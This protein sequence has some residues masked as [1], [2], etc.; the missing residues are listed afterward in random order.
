MNTVSGFLVVLALGA[1]PIEPSFSDRSDDGCH[2]PCYVVAH[3]PHKFSWDGKCE[4]K[5]ADNQCRL[6][7]SS[8]LLYATS[9]VEA[10][11]QA[12]ATLRSQANGQGVVVEGTVSVSVHVDLF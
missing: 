8:G 4:I 6:V 5:C 1:L 9:E 10:R 12:E 7:C 3:S 2:G 11:A